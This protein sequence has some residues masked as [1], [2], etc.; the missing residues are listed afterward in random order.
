MNV[1]VNK[2]IPEFVP[3]SQITDPL[4]DVDF[5]SV[6][7]EESDGDIFMLLSSRNVL[8]WNKIQS[9]RVEQLKACEDYEEMLDHIHTIRTFRL[10]TGSITL[11]N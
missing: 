10:F 2:D 6:L 3:F 8:S 4:R 9:C 7:I 5:Y 1:K 11:S